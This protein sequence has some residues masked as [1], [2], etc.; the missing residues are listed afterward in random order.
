LNVKILRSPALG[1]G[2]ALTIVL[3]ACS[4]NGGSSPSAA[5]SGAASANASGSAV[6]PPTDIGKNDSAQVTGAGS[7]AI[8]PFLSKIADEYQKNVASG[9]SVNYQSIGS[10]GGIAQFTANTVDFGA[11]D[12][13]LSDA[14]EAQIGVP[15]FNLPMIH[16]AVAVT[17]NIPNFSA[18]MQL[19]PD[20]IAKI[21]LGT[22]TSW[23]DAAIAADN[24]GVSLPDLPITVVHR[25]DGSGTTYNFT[26][27]LSGISSDWKS[28]VGNDTSVNWPT[29][30]GGK[31]SEGVT[32]LVEKTPGAITYVDLTY[33]LS[34]NLPVASIKNAAGNY[35]AP[36]LASTTAAVA[37]QVP[38]AP[39]DLRFLIVNPPSSAP[40]A[41]PIGAS[42][43]VL[44]RKDYPADKQ[45]EVTAMVHFLWWAIHDGQSYA[46][47]VN[48]SAMA[49]NL[50]TLAEQVLKQITVGGQPV[51]P[52][53]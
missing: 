47:D 20:T 36:T 52:A 24:P 41:Y 5:A 7:T 33:A 38:T 37:A 14:Q 51:L 9:V 18:T 35:V 1:A 12:V 44:L 16:W 13:Y 22:I 23:N 43:W 31:G 21:F 11:S 17:Y 46:A 10:G 27:F 8:F 45:A 32:G 34:N 53:S 30:A 39:A 48:Y 40:D 19:S 25:S 29:G 28:Q 50:V 49:P 3:A 2:L 15:V 4:S 26:A 6:S 42:T